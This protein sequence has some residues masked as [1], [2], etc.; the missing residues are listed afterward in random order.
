MILLISAS[1]TADFL[2]MKHMVSDINDYSL[3]VTEIS[4]DICDT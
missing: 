1:Q 3:F 4:F 2:T